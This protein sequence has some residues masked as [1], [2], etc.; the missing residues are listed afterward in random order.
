VDEGGGVDELDDGGVEDG[1]VALVAAEA[2][3]HEEHGRAHPL[4]AA[5]LDVLAHLR[6]E[7]DARLEVARELALDTR[8]F[9]ANGLEDFGKTRNG[10]RWNMHD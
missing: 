7:L 9:V 10:R 5:H 8:Q 1:T 4:A 6:D 3:R 2:R